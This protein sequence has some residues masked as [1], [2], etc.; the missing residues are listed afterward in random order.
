MV[1]FD[2]VQGESL[3]I[4]DGIVVT[5]VYSWKPKTARLAIQAPPEVPIWRSELS[6]GRRMASHVRRS[7]TRPRMRT[8]LSCLWARRPGRWCS[9]AGG[10]KA[11][12]LDSRAAKADKDCSRV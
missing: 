5:V 3:V 1:M 10:G 6:A 2:L 11:A 8:G 12:D 7:V 4:G 9:L